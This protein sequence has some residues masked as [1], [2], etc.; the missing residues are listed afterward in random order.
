MRR[1]SQVS[2]SQ[3]PL[4]SFL[5]FLFPFL[6]SLS[7]RLCPQPF[8]VPTTAL[9]PACSHFPAADVSEPTCTCCNPSNEHW[10]RFG[11]AN[12]ILTCA[13]TIVTALVWWLRLELR[14][15]AALPL[16]AALWLT[17]VIFSMQSQSLGPDKQPPMV[18][19]RL[20]TLRSCRLPLPSRRFPPSS[21]R[22]PLPSLNEISR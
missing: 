17:A 1:A 14:V 18:A 8:L 11:K 9:P 15:Y 10:D 7:P 5:S 3:W 6:F 22:F 20:R 13:V 19:A 2:T 12:L 16:V 21:C 4:A